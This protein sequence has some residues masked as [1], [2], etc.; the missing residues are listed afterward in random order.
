M[1]C[2]GAGVTCPPPGCYD[3][4]VDSQ[5]RSVEEWKEMIFNE[6]RNFTPRT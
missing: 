2:P 5:S 3:P 6:V 4:D 1:L